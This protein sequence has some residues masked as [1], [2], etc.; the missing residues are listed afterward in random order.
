MNSSKFRFTLDLHSTHSQYSIPVMVGDT[1][2]TLLISIT[3]G[4]VPYLMGEG[5]LAK[6][7][8]RR[9]G[10]SILKETCMIRNGSVI[11]YPFE[12]NENTCAMEGVHY[13]DITLET[14]DGARLGSPRFTLVVSEMVVRSDEIT[15][16]DETRTWVY[17]MLS[18]E[19]VRDFQESLRVEAEK[20][21]VIAEA[22]RVAAEAKRGDITEYIL[23]AEESANRAEKAAEGI[24]SYEDRVSRNEKL[25]ANIE[26]GYSDDF[27]ITD[28]TSAAIKLVPSNVAPYAEI[29]KLYGVAS[30]ANNGKW[31]ANKPIRIEVCE[32]SKASVL[33]AT[34]DLSDMAD[35]MTVEKLEDGSF[36]FNGYT[37]D[38]GNGGTRKFA[39]VE[40][41]TGTYNLSYNITSNS[42]GVVPNLYIYTTNGYE[43]LYSYMVVS[44]GSLT[45]L[46]DIDIG[47]GLVAEDLII[48]FEA[49]KGTLMG[50]DFVGELIPKAALVI[51]DEVVEM[52]GYGVSGNWIDFEAGVFHLAREIVYGAAV[53][54]DPVQ[55]IDI[56]EH[57][58]YDNF[59]AVEPNDY[60]RV[61]REGE[62]VGQHK[63][64]IVYM[65]GA[66]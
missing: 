50:S 13:C 3:D 57:I 38:H 4:G 55:D 37:S 20:K 24:E 6:L 44:G 35:T 33:D 60:I 40:L 36:R 16:S 54:V 41:P 9:P 46:I 56:R 53:S 2:V 12:Q 43:Q 14:P 58:G 52:R 65:K 61:I 21:R 47:S 28:D 27:F 49:L 18:A 1:S 19:G 15:L 26:K 48:S 45:L 22:E 11:E 62:E 39:T 7:S 5:C 63:T 66:N 23:K 31:V 10:G 32:V 59:L 34:L 51:P 17:A 8:I 25:L 64:V 30:K 29:K 42:S